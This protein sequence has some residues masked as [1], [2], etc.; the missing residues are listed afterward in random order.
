MRKKFVAIACAAML[1][2]AMPALAF[3]ADPANAGGNISAEMNPSAAQGTS[4]D[5]N[6]G[7]DNYKPEPGEHKTSWYSPKLEGAIG[8]SWGYDDEGNYF[9]A[10]VTAKGA[11]DIEVVKT[12]EKA[13]NFDNTKDYTKVQSFEVTSKDFKAGKDLV[14]VAWV[15]G[16][17]ATGYTCYAYV[18]HGDGSA[19]ESFCLPIDP[20]GRVTFT[21]GNL[22][23]ITFGLTAETFDQ[24]AADKYNA[25]H[26]YGGDVAPQVAKAVA[27][28]NKAESP[29]TG[30]AL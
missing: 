21:M 10:K 13:S 14:T 23:T 26:N 4:P 18:E 17:D 29:K 5:D 7:P 16:V 28:D 22:S 27:T 12:D 15:A 19:P 24:A 9:N 8:V 1:A 25:A 3:A 11:E 6:Q 30:D 2:L 20:S